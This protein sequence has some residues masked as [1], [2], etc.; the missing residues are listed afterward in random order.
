[1]FKNVDM[2]EALGSRVIF[3]TAGSCVCESERERVAD[4]FFSL[5]PIRERE[6]GA[7]ERS[8]LTSI[9][10]SDKIWAVL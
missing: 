4:T 6:G 3:S 8:G 10:F 2:E 1:M 5:F 9:V 7:L